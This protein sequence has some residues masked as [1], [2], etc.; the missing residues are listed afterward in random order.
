[1]SVGESPIHDT[2]PGVN[3]G[4]WV[5]AVREIARC[6]APAGYLRQR[7]SRGEPVAAARKEHFREAGDRLRRQPPTIPARNPCG[8]VALKRAS[9]SRY[10]DSSS[11]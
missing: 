4:W 2:G 1:M 8:K 7:R 9:S 10:D 5:G 11:S 6:F 3:S